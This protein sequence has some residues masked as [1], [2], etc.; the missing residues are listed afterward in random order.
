MISLFITF[1]YP[2]APIEK[3]ETML[4]LIFEGIKLAKDSMNLLTLGFV[5]DLRE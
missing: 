1:I 2:G 5:K 4:V 3:G